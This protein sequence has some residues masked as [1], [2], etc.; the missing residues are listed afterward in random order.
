MYKI[1]KIENSMTKLDIKTFKELGFTERYHLQEWI[2]K[3]PDCLG[4]ELL[5]IQKEFSGFSDTNERLDLLAL[6]KEGNLVIIENKLDDS[7]KDVTWQAI[8]Y[9]S[10]CS[11]FSKSDIERIYLEYTKDENYKEKLCDFFDV[12]NYD[13]I[14]IEN[15]KQRIILVAANFRKEVTSAVLWLRNK[16]LDIKCFRVTPYEFNQEYFLSI[17]QI[18]PVKEIQDYMIEIARKEQEQN[19][20]NNFKKQTH[21]IR[22][23]FW[24]KLLN[25]IKEENFKLFSNISPSKDSWISAGSGFGFCCY[26]FVFNKDCV[27]I[28]LYID[29][30]DKDKNKAIFDQLKENKEALDNDFKDLKWERLENK[31]ACRIKFEKEYDSYNEANWDEMIEF[32]I[33][34]MKKFENTM[35]GYIQKIKI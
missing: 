31:R 6:D 19:V 28:E 21:I 30:K 9:A 20:I 34:N 14:K 10:Y 24:N 15:Q 33:E 7:G 27:K 23:K 1:S 22:L 18:I 8:K 3:S 25:K 4:E 32:M 29:S 11:T 26:S 13:D 5:I 35:K 16:D 17:E 12:N 2:V